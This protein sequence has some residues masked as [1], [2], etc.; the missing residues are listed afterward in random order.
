MARISLRQLLNL[1]AG[2]AG[3]ITPITLADM[4]ARYASGKLDPVVSKEGV[5]A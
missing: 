2:Q 3:R 1:V 4:A 5:A